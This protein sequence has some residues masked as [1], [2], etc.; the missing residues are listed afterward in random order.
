MKMRKM[1]GLVFLLGIPVFGME[2]VLPASQDNT[3]RANN[4]TRNNGSN[5]LLY[6]ARSPAARVIIAF[7]LSLIT[8]EVEE[9]V[10]R[11]RQQRNANDSP[12]MII[13][14][15]VYTENNAS[16]KEG[17]GDGGMNGQNARLG[18]SCWAFSVYKSVPWEDADGKPLRD[19]NEPRL[20]ANPVARLEAVPWVEGRW[21]EVKIPA[22]L[23]ETVRKRKKPVL[24]LGLWG[25]SGTGYYF[26][27]SRNSSYSPELVLKIKEKK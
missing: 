26:I 18:E 16:W 3:L 5:R 9:A 8:N 2:V 10:F 19:V 12:D 27:N 24:T 7:D 1:L 21:V 6:I 23:V 20:W 22:S 14:P 11:F 25:T 15:M 17:L 4:R 13:A